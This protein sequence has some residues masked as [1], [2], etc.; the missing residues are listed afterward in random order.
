MAK[1]ER[2]IVSKYSAN[3]NDF[4]IFHSFV[5]KDRS[6]LAKR[7]CDRFQGVG[8]DGLIV[9]TPHE[10]FDFEWEFYNCDG[11]VPYM[12]G[13][14]SRAAAHYAYAK[15]LAKRNMSF[16]TL[17]GAIECQVNGNLVQS[18]LTPFKE[19]AKP[20]SEF[21]S[22]WYFFDTGVPHLVTFEL[23]FDHQKA[24]F[25]REKYNANVNF[26]QLSNTLHVRTYERGIEGETK[27]CGTGMVASFLSAHFYHNT[28]SILKV[29]PTG[30]DE[31]EVKLENGKTYLTGEVK[32]VFVADIYE[33]MD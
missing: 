11:S 29:Y 17:A 25:M 3:G 15:S 21:D 9:L 27:A 30:G 19:V 1:G 28:P 20:F 31:L 5:K 16:L 18:Q 22:T 7:L 10:K 12:C 2:L 13:N 32:E 14:G 4:V 26:C 6:E 23:E 24:K 33:V 8:A